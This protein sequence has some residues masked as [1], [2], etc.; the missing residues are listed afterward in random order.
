MM[1]HINLIIIP[2]QYRNCNADEPGTFHIITNENLENQQPVQFSLSFHLVSI[3][4][5]SYIVFS[6]KDFMT[7]N[8][9]PFCWE[10]ILFNPFVIM[11]ICNVIVNEYLSNFYYLWVIL[12]IKINAIKWWSLM[13]NDDVVI[14]KI[15]VEL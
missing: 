11:F 9:F 13:F 14:L 3:T 10:Q 15:W 6:K 2:L 5:A 8:I 12:T 1:I 7:R 4:T